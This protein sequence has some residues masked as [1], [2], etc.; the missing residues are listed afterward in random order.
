M[1]GMII[2]VTVDRLGL[3][4]MD[5]PRWIPLGDIHKP[6]YRNPIFPYLHGRV[7][8]SHQFMVGQTYVV[9]MGDVSMTMDVHGPMA[10]IQTDASGRLYL[11]NGVEKLDFIWWYEASVAPLLDDDSAWI[12]GRDIKTAYRLRSILQ[13]VPGWD[14][15]QH[16]FHSED[17]K[18]DAMK[19]MMLLHSIVRGAETMERTIHPATVPVRMTPEQPWKNVVDENPSTLERLDDLPPRPRS[20]HRCE[21]AV[22]FPDR[23][24]ME[25]G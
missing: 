18:R 13:G 15:R 11:A 9:P 21:P 2:P 17:M 8:W 23:V 3:Q 6:D 19:F 25:R 4:M 10:D 1:D 7:Y 22:D 20:C 5:G 16:H 14:G 24:D 12:K